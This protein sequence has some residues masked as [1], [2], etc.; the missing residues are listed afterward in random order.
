MRAA[1]K[2]WNANCV[3]NA[4]HSIT[5]VV[6]SSVTAANKLAVNA[7]VTLRA[8]GNSGENE[9]FSGLNFLLR[10]RSIGRTRDFESRYLGSSPSAA[11]NFY[12]LVR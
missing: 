4:K 3:L 7:E 11:T 2:R 1:R 10:C 5:A 6:L 12:M 8:R 9:V